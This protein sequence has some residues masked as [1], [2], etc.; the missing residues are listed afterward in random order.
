MR[1]RMRVEHKWH[2]EGALDSMI[3]ARGKEGHKK[4]SKLYGLISQHRKWVLC[5]PNEGISDKVDGKM[6]VCNDL[7]HLCVLGILR[8]KYM[9]H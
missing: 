2:R 3:I 9:R 5:Y 1:G 4:Q 6:W 7:K 8:S